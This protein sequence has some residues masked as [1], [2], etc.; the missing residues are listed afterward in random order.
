VQVG[1]RY[2]GELTA[3]DWSGMC[4]VECRPGMALESHARMDGQHLG[5]A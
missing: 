3:E 1:L 5:W 2:D 4:R